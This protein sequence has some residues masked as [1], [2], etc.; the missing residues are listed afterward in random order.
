MALTHAASVKNS[1]PGTTRAAN[2]RVP[3]VAARIIFVILFDV[4]P[5]RMAHTAWSALRFPFATCEPAAMAAAWTS[6]KP[7][8]VAAINIYFG[9]DIADKPMKRGPGG[10][11]DC[12]NG[13]KS[14]RQIGLAHGQS[15]E[16][17]CQDEG[18]FRR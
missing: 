8:T 6:A 10:K 13:R 7:A 18:D 1:M 2:S 12:D 11:Q 14:G 9:Q 5:K 4:K 15:A 17:Q 3:A 16:N